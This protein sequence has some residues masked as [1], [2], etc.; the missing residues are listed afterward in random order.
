AKAFEDALSYFDG[1]AVGRND[2]GKLFEGKIQGQKFELTGVAEFDKIIEALN[3]GQNVG[4]Y[5]GAR[6]KEYN[7]LIA[8]YRGLIE[9]GLL[10]PIEFGFESVSEITK[11]ELDNMYRLIEEG[12][13]D[14][15]TKRQVE[16]IIAQ[17]DL[18]RE[19]T[20]QL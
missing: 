8:Y 13:L 2:F 12:K 3:S 5:Y 4:D 20:N 10:K 9:S 1:R 11:T 19:A 16:N 18:W 15:A 17:Y 14:E 6:G 7:R